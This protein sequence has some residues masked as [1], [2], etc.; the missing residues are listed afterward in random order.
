[1]SYMICE[2]CRKH[3][4]LDEGK[5]SFNYERCECGGK[6]KY[7]SSLEENPNTNMKSVNTS[8][9]KVMGVIIGFIFLFVSLLLSVLALFGTDI[10]IN[11]LNL[12]SRILYIFSIS[13]VILTVTSGSLSS[14][15]S[16]SGRYRDGAINGGLVGVILGLILGIIGGVFV[17]LSGILVFGFFSMLGGLISS[18]LRK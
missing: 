17:L 12:S 10:H 7:S 5:S 15:I 18:F 8:N 11:T 14:Y 3:Y 1:M 4:P 6:L 13:T 9:K 16:G 2:K